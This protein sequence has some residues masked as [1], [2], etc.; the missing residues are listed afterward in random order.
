MT[1]LSIAHVGSP[2]MNND[3]NGVDLAKSVPCTSH[4]EAD[5][6]HMEG[7]DS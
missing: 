1:D 2:D 3:M 6:T 5:D 7:L 4:M